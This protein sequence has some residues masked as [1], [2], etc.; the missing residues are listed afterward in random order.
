MTGFR[1]F[2]K[3]L[4]IKYW[5]ILGNYDRRTITVPMWRPSASTNHVL[6][7]MNDVEAPAVYVSVHLSPEPNFFQTFM[8][9]ELNTFSSINAAFTVILMK[10]TY[11]HQM[12]KNYNVRLIY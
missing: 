4:K 10:Y 7:M 3:Q 2:P 1:G 12:Q 8:E 11:V 9:E 6:F 5:I